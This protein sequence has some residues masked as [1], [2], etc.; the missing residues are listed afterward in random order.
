MSRP[1]PASPA[2][3]RD[4]SACRRPTRRGDDLL[5]WSDRRAGW[6]SARH[7]SPSRVT[8]IA[9]SIRRIDSPRGPSSKRSDLGS[10][11]PVVA[12]SREASGAISCTCSATTITR[13]TSSADITRFEYNAQL[14]SLSSG[15]ASSS[16]TVRRPTDRTG[17]PAARRP[18]RRPSA[19][20]QGATGLHGRSTL[21][22]TD[23]HPDLPHPR[24]GPAGSPEWTRPAVAGGPQSSRTR[25]RD[26]SMR[27]PEIARLITSSWI[28]SVPSKMS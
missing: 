5:S 27:K 18:S 10:R 2:A 8:V 1:A 13:S 12:A 23:E 22:A 24:R 9:R 25:R 14:G 4:A 17:T 20:M 28:C 3:G 11:A 26:Y 7:S 19:V 15:H 6:P 16:C 21:V